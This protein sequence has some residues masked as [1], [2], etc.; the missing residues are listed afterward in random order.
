MK[1]ILL[2][3]NSILTFSIA[4]GQSFTL[5][6]LTKMTTS[7]Q[8]SVIS[9]LT[10]KSFT[11]S[12]TRSAGEDIIKTYSKNVLNANSEAVYIGLRL[13]DTSGNWHNDVTYITGSIRYMIDLIKQRGA[14]G[15]ALTN[16]I[17][18]EEMTT[19]SYET[20][21]FWVSVSNPNTGK[22]LFALVISNK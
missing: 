18:G 14:L 19:H 3:L 7:S 17:T 12:D 22:G 11:L 4:F 13:Q 2:A 10:S 15:L 9:E 8:S 20:D 6:E 5:K 1:K 16:K 21:S